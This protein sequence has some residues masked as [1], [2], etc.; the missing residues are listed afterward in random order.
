DAHLVGAGPQQRVDVVDTAHAAAHGQRDEHLV[1]RAAHHVV[2]RL[3]AGR[4]GGDIQKGQLVGALGVV[5]GGQLDRIAGVP[6][7]LEVHALDAP[8][9]VDVQAGDHPYRN[10]HRTA[11]S[12]SGRV[13]APA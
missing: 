2:G 7:A 3:A 8:P 1:G 12:A 10:G 11:A 4:R 6:P 5:A 9:G 13:N